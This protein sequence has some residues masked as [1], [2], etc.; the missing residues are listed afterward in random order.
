M[1]STLDKLTEEVDA[2]LRATGMP[3]T[4]FGRAVA[5]DPRL[6]SRLRQGSDVTTTTADRIRRYMSEYASSEV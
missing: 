2:F 1:K 6:V 5:N 3:K 4:N